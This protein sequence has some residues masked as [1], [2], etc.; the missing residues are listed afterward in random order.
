[1]QPVSVMHYY[2]HIV[3]VYVKEKLLFANFHVPY[4]TFAILPYPDGSRAG[5]EA[6]VSRFGGW[7]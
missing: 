7:G 4:E 2:D 3:V 1:M 5:G 6:L